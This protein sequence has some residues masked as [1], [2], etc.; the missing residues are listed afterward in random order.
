MEDHQP[1]YKTKPKFLDGINTPEGKG[2][3]GCFVS[4]LCLLIAS[5]LLLISV[6]IGIYKT[7]INETKNN[8]PQTEQER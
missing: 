8:N 2:I 1:T 6:L 5:V 3:A 7:K 4:G